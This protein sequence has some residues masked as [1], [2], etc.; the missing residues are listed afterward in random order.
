[1][2]E[3]I[4]PYL[5]YLL[6]TLAAG[7]P[8]FFIFRWVYSQWWKANLPAFWGWVLQQRRRDQVIKA[9]R[10]QVADLQHRL[11]VLEATV[12][13]DSAT[14]E[15]NVEQEDITE[16]LESTVI[17]LSDLERLVAQL[18]HRLRSRGIMSDP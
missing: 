3:S 7:F 10:E 18:R 5:P 4:D 12:G 1:M 2:L 16:R 11:L 14:D 6:Y 17:R 8:A 13:E 15:T 9:T